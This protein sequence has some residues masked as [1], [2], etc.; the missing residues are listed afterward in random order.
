[1]VGFSSRRLRSPQTSQRSMC[2]LTRL[3]IS[4]VSSPSQP[5]RISA[6]S[7]QYSCPERATSS[8]PSDVSNWPR[9]RE[10]S[11]CA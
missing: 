5:S 3:R 11:A 8:T 1:M 7:G 9:A 2:R 4:G 6:R 10:A